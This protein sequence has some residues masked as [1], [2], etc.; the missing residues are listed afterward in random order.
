MSMEKD[1]N[2][3]SYYGSIFSNL[4]RGLSITEG[5]SGG[6]PTGRQEKDDQEVN[7]NSTT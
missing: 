1:T 2:L 4:S 3:L 7:A 5:D 6:E